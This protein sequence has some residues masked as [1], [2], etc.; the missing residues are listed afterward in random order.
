MKPY[1]TMV[2]SGDNT[3][4]G[5]VIAYNQYGKESLNAYLIGTVENGKNKL[6][7]YKFSADSTVIRTN[8][9]R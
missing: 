4:I 7:L 6:E 1:Y 9:I 3:E 2:K 8:A 5:L